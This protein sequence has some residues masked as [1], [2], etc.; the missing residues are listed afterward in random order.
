MPYF[1]KK[2]LMKFFSLLIFLNVLMMESTLVCEQLKKSVSEDGNEMLRVATKSEGFFSVSN[3]YSAQH[4]KH[5]NIPK[6]KDVL[7][8]RTQ[9]LDFSLFIIFMCIDLSC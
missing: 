4:E 5:I 6:I 1:F 8:W 2:A 9:A 7:I 3:V